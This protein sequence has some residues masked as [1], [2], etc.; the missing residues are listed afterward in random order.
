P[1]VCTV[2]YSPLLLYTTLFRSELT[3]TYAE[4]ELL[5]TFDVEAEAYVSIVGESNKNYFDGILEP[6]SNIDPIDLSDESN[7]FLN[8]GKRYLD[9]KSTRLNSSHVSISYAVF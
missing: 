3:F 5:L 1:H 7:V 9:R 8:I 4:E 2:L 6:N